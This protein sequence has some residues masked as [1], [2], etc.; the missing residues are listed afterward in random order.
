VLAVDD[1]GYNSLYELADTNAAAVA[2]LKPG[3]SIVLAAHVRQTAGG[4]GI[5]FGIAKLLQ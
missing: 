1:S 4:Q 5:D 3:A 2:L